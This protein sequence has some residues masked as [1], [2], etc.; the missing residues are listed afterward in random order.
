MKKLSKSILYLKEKIYN[1]GTNWDEIGIKKDEIDTFVVKFLNNEPNRIDENGEFS[2][3]Y[4]LASSG[5]SISDRFRDG[6]PEEKDH[7]IEEMLKKY[8][9]KTQ[10]IVYRGIPQA[11]FEK[12]YLWAKN[13]KGVDL[14]DEGFLSTSLIK[15][16]EEAEKVR[17]RIL[18]PKGINA[19]YMG[20]VAFE[21]E[22][23]YELTVQ[24][25]AQ[26]KIIS[27]DDTYYNCKLLRT[28]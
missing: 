20:D 7:K 17:L 9:T 6:H 28:M 11:L 25:G 8:K 23:Y 26:L 19:V 4:L 18:I 2:L 3:E 22:K 15:G 24:R 12:M 13:V 16:H 21:K 14:I 5:M 10:V 27:V 1:I